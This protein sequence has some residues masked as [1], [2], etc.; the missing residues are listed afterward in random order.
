MSFG[1][2]G[3]RDVCSVAF[4]PPKRRGG[5]GTALGEIVTGHP[6]GSLLVWRGGA[7][8]RA[9]E[10]AHGRGARAIQPDGSV[11]WGLSLIHI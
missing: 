2:H 1:S 9:V 6:D 8:F 11:A 5:E 4:L 3:V 10:G 7:A